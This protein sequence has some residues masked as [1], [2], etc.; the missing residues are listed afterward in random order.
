MGFRMSCD[1]CGRFMKNV[2]MTDLKGLGNNEIVCP[3]CQKVESKAKGDIERLKNVAQGEINKLVSG[4]QVQMV[5][6]IQRH[7]ED[8]D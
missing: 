6:I 1:R 2:K 7:V 3:V 8:G 4:F 5:E